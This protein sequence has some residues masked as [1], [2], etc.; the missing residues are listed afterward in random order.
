MKEEIIVIRVSKEFKD[1][2]QTEASGLQLGFSGYCRMILRK[3]FNRLDEEKK[4]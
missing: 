4:A 3:E 1:R 2:M